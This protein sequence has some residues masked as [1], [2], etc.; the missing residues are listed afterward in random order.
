ML[1]PED[2]DEQASHGR[3]LVAGGCRRCSQQSTR[4][5]LAS[6]EQ[7]IQRAQRAASSSE[8]HGATAAAA[9]AA[10]AAGEEWVTTHHR[11]CRVQSAQ[12]RRNPASTTSWSSCWCPHAVIPQT[13]GG[14]LPRTTLPFLSPLPHQPPRQALRQVG[15]F[16]AGAHSRDGILPQPPASSGFRERQPPRQITRSIDPEI[17]SRIIRVSGEGRGGSLRPASYPRQ[18]Q[19]WG[20]G[21]GLKRKA[22]ETPGGQTLVLA[23]PARHPNNTLPVLCSVEIT[24]RT[25]NPTMIWRKCIIIHSSM[26]WCSPPHQ[27]AFS[28]A[29]GEVSRRECVADRRSVLV[30]RFLAS[31]CSRSAASLST[32]PGR[33]GAGLQLQLAKKR[34]AV[35]A[36]K[37]WAADWAGVWRSLGQVAV[38]GAGDDVRCRLDGTPDPGQARTGLRRA[39]LPCASALCVVQLA[40]VAAGPSHATSDRVSRWQASAHWRI[41]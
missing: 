19:R 10:W 18:G 1:P 23:A 22:K 31:N 14:S 27:D 21:P 6:N 30:P 29:S 28:R 35:R 36:G 5:S 24:R 33:C 11:R 9:R 40:A 15:V 8:R 16:A 4:W 2:G 7:R 12:S 39:C 26:E 37:C 25:E 34:P 41:H 38:G 17:D 3:G 20:E 32:A 13:E